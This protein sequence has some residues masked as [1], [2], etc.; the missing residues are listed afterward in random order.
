[1]SERPLG[2]GSEVERGGKDDVA[3]DERDCLRELGLEV[4][5]SYGLCRRTHLAQRLLDPAHGADH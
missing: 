5:A 2:A 3:L 1:M 4:R